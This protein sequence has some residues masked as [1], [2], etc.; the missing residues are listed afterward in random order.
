MCTVG[1]ANGATRSC[2]SDVVGTQ[3]APSGLSC[4]CSHTPKAGLRSSDRDHVASECVPCLTLSRK[5][6]WLA[7]GAG[8]H[9][10]AACSFSSVLAPILVITFLTANGPEYSTGWMPLVFLWRSLLAGPLYAPLLSFSQ[11]GSHLSNVL[12]NRHLAA[13]TMFPQGTGL[14]PLPRSVLRSAVDRSRY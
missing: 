14:S 2:L 1:L 5:A 7:P 9:G 10:S 11:W 4:I 12:F 6:C 8:A 3:A 13:P